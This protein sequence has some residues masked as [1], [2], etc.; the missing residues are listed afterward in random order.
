MPRW[1]RVAS[2]PVM[3]VAGGLTSVQ[4]QI[5]GTFRA[6][7]G[8]GLRAAGMAATVSMLGGLFTIMVIALLVPAARRGVATLVRSIRSGAYPWW[9]FVGGCVGGVFV[10]SQALAVSVIGV[11][12][13]AVAAVAGQTTASLVVDRTSLAPGGPQPLSAAR[14][15]AASAAIAAVFVASVGGIATDGGPTWEIVVLVLLPFLG[16]AGNAFQQAVNGRV[17]QIAGPVPSTALNVTLATTVVLV[18]LCATLIAPGESFHAWPTQWWMYLAG[19][20]GLL[21][22]FLAAILVH[23]HGVLTLALLTIAGQVIAAEILN[24]FAPGGAMTPASAVA[25]LLVVAGVAVAL[26]SARRRPVPSAA[27]RAG[28]S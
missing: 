8:T 15:V 28:T 5:T 20:I 24:A 22:I 7:L 12:L 26:F 17:A 6:E 23:V 2:V 14:V 13:F 16:G 11:A 25:A 4:A 10:L 3:V 18:F 19:L 21:F 9:T 27:A 1:V